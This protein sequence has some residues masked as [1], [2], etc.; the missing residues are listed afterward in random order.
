MQ[1]RKI[2][3]VSAIHYGRLVYRSVLF[4]LLLT[5]YIL[6]RIKGGDRI[7]LKFDEHMPVI[8]IVTWVL[9]VL[10]MIH[11]F[12]PS[13]Y[14]SPGRQKQFKRNYIKTGNT[15][16]VI[17]DNH[18]TVLV[19]LLWIA[20]NAVFGALHMAGIF[21]D[22]IMFL[23]CSFYSV[24]DMV[25]ILF[26]CPFQT[27]F[28]KN[29]CCTVCRIYN[30]DFAMMFTPLFFVKGIFSWSILGLALALVLRWEITYYRHPERFS[31]N[32]N[33]YLKCKNCTER[34]CQHKTQ[35]DA[36]WKHIEAYTKERVRRLKKQD[37]E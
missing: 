2:S 16:I 10:E 23:I 27:L 3:A 11:R 6:S 5:G 13:K 26:F 17:Q 12:I 18:A 22:G 1:K 19:A 28:L 29:K 33:A 36:L 31:E 24:G 8:L 15:E 7:T 9:F 20:V 37:I 32:T 34:L 4:L 30:W 14:D 35:L 25:C 21:D